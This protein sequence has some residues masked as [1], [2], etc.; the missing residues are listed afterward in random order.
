V[1]TLEIIVQGDEVRVLASEEFVIDGIK[2][3][4]TLTSVSIHQPPFR[5]EAAPGSECRWHCL[6]SPRPGN[7]PVLRDQFGGVAE[8][9][10]AGTTR[11][12]S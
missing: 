9:H 4:G 10:S 6:P 12:G 5:R 8:D 7:D 2:L 3:V 11:F 1:A